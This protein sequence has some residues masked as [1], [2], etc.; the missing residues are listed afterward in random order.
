VAHAWTECAAHGA[1]D[2]MKNLLILIKIMF[3]GGCATTPTVKS[4]AGA[5]EIKEGERSF[6][7]VFLESGVVEDYENGKKI[8]EGK[9]KLTKEGELHDTYSNG[10]IAVY[11]I[12]KDGSIT[13][14][15]EIRKGGKRKEHPKDNQIYTY[16]R[17]K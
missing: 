13:E 10:Y 3:V 6:R 16:K 17:I 4:V 14:I 11:R 8:E 15:A 7:M 5:Y 9:W 12:N 2:E 1:G